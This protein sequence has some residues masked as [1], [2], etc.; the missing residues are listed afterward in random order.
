MTVRNTRLTDEE[1][2]QERKKVLAM[3][4]T[5][6][7]VDLDEAVEYHHRMAETKNYV[8][9]LQE[10]KQNGTTSFCSMMGTAPLEKDIECSRYLQVEGQSDFLSTVVDSMTRNQLFEKAERELREI[11]KAGRPLL[12]GFPIVHYG[13]TGTRKKIEAVDMPVMIWGP[14]PETR[15]IDEIAL[16]GGHTGISH[17]GGDVRLFSLYQATAPGDLH[18]ELSVYL[19]APGLLYGE[20]N[21]DP[22]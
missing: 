4:P 11:E 12:N 15:L 14:S 8:L 6:K 3:W 20:G 22:A 17:G 13:V 2:F 7:D 5:G 1:F 16:A 10:A 19:S 18:T 9:K 21:S